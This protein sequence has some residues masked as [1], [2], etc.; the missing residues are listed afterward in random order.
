MPASFHLDFE[1]VGL[2]FNE[3]VRMVEGQ[4]DKA[5]QAGP[6]SCPSKW[7]CHNGDR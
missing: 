5:R 4:S 1:V 7:G 3:K 6:D 2:Y